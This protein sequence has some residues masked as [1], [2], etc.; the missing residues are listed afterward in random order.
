MRQVI[1][2]VR[3]STSQRTMLLFVLHV[4]SLVVFPGA[5]SKEVSGATSIVFTCTLRHYGLLLWPAP[6]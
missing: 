6:W 2:W 1:T 4:P 3:T 5:Q